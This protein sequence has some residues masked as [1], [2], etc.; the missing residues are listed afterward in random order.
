[1]DEQGRFL[2]RISSWLPSHGAHLGFQPVRDAP[3]PRRFGS[4]E[5]LSTEALAA[6]VDGELP[7]GAQV[8]ANQHLSLCP[9]CTAE[10]DAQRQARSALRDSN[11]ITAP[12]TLLGMLSKIPL[13][14]PVPPDDLIPDSSAP[15]PG[16]DD[17]RRNPGR[18]R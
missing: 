16:D 11:P 2:R 8:R 15:A 17:P 13:A 5:H 18:R 10:V 6:Y 12:S 7:M 14:P 4:T 1:M 3:G 9:Q